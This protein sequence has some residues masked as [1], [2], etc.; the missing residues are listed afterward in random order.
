MADIASTGGLRHAGDPAPKPVLYAQDEGGLRPATESDILVSTHELLK[1]RFRAGVPI[2]SYPELLKSFLQA[3]T[4]CQQCCVFVAVFVTRSEQ[5]IQVAELFRGTSRYVNI[6]PKE[7]ARAALACE[8]EGVICARTDPTG[9][10]EPTE[11]DINAARWLRRLFDVMETPMVDYI[12]VGEKMT[13]LR[14]KG[15]L[16]MNE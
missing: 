1:H 13:S 12:V 5:L 9:K 16:Q 10:A 11:N 3:K 4:G 14:K 2:T 8:A 15:L 7:V 6:Y